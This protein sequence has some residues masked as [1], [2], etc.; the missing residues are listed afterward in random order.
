MNMEFRNKLI[1]SIVIAILWVVGIISAAEAGKSAVTVPASSVPIP[2]ALSK[3]MVPVMIGACVQAP[4]VDGIL[5]DACWQSVLAITNFHLMNKPGPIGH[6]QAWITYDSSWLYIAFA[7][8]HP[9]PQHLTKAITR[10]GGQVCDDDSV[11]LFI[12]PGT[13]G[14][15]YFHYMLNAANVGTERRCEVKEVKLKVKDIPWRSATLE[16]MQGWNAEIAIP[17]AFLA[18]YGDLSKLRMNVTINRVL[19]II[20]GAKARIGDE[21]EQ[22]SWASLIKSNHEPDRFVPLTGINGKSIVEPFFPRLG[23]VQV[24]RYVWTNNTYCYAISGEL[25]NASSRTGT[26]ELLVQD[27]PLGGSPS[28]KRWVFAIADASRQTICCLMPVSNVVGRTARVTLQAPPRGDVFQVELLDAEAMHVLEIMSAWLDRSYYTDERAARLIALVNL[29]AEDLDAMRLTVLD[30]N[31][32]PLGQKASLTPQ[33]EIEVPLAALACS[34]HA[35]TV[36]LSGANQ[37]AMARHTLTLIK[38]SPKPGLEWKTDRDR[39][40]LL[41]N[42]QPFFPFGF[43]AI[44]PQNPGPESAIREVAEAGFNAFVL[45]SS[46]GAV[47]PEQVKT[48]SRLMEKYH[49]VFFNYLDAYHPEQVNSISRLRGQLADKKIADLR[50]RQQVFAR[51]YDTNLPY[52]LKG[53]AAVKDNP[54][55]MGY[56]TLD[57]PSSSDT[58]GMYRWGRDLYRKTQAADG[59][60]PTLVNFSSNI[61]QGEEWT[62]WC[63]ILC[64]DP[65]WFTSGIPEKRGTPNYVSKITW[66]TKQ[67]G[68]ALHKPVMI[69]PMAE[70]WGANHKRI[71]SPEEQRCQT[72]LALIYGAKGLF[73][74]RYPLYHQLSF[75]V[76]SQLAGEVRELSPSLLAPEWR[77]HITYSSGTPAPE[78]G[79]FPDVQAAL[80]RHGKDSVLLLCANSRPFPVDVTYRF[81]SAGIKGPVERL[82]AT[83]RYDVSADGFQDHVEPYGTRAYRVALSREPQEPVEV[84]LALVSHPETALKD[85]PSYPY[86]G[87]PGKKNIMPNPG[88]EVSTLPGMPDYI[89]PFQEMPPTERFEKP[90]YPFVLDKTNPYEGACCLKISAEPYGRQGFHLTLAPPGPQPYVFSVYM[91]GEKDGAVATITNHGWNLPSKRC[92]L[93]TSWQRY[94]VS[95]IIPA[96]L[97]YSHNLRIFCDKGTIWIDAMQLEKGTEPTVYEP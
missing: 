63:D 41:N 64:T 27:T 3:P 85:N 75:G 40:I 22:N 9:D 36:E 6:Q 5:T 26:V 94:W 29:P 71:I 96:G 82:F 45:W 58:V 30:S 44:L 97:G 84:M 89:R 53:I 66:L 62:D 8:Q 25:I 93:T 42:G 78:K 65:Y 33:T 35:L 92:V 50:E 57:E 59:Y 38:R 67:R 76:L 87:R 54:A 51:G 28:D 16:T 95:G 14:T 11:E 46:G 13:E 73:Y 55:L 88:F 56:V 91:R 39:R 43:L 20:D 4:V 90:G 17:L 2:V 12:D 21:M 31:G 81:P 18:T 70:S 68:D 77:H 15:L 86:T 23:A 34:E 80:F 7:I 47:T 37:A 32:R 24:G 74:F 60:H 69:I 10:H 19:P 48:I 79:L 83:N 61:P 1:R 72:Y 49:L 52:I